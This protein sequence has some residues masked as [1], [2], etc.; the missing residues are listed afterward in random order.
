MEEFD[1]TCPYC[2]K[3]YHYNGHSSLSSAIMCDCGKWIHGW[4]LQQYAKEEI[5]EMY[6]KR[7]NTYCDFVWVCRDPC[8]GEGSNS[9]VNILGAE[10]KPNL[11]DTDDGKVWNYAP[12]GFMGFMKIEDFEKTFGF[13]VPKGFCQQCEITVHPIG[14]PESMESQREVKDNG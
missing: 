14:D 5:V 3:T 8:D 2:K 4:T 12:Q 6:M 7:L 11:I 9:C 10:K 13:K 1:Y